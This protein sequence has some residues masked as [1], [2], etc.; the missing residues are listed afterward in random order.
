MDWL[1]EADRDVERHFPRISI[2]GVASIICSVK[3]A[4][5][6]TLV[7]PIFLDV[8]KSATSKKPIVDLGF[9]LRI[10]AHSN[11]WV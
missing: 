4:F 11:C 9:L 8:G 5:G 6:A 7:R 3:W 10:F 2:P 1:F